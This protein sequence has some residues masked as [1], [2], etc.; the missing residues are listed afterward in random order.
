MDYNEDLWGVSEIND[1]FTNRNY[2]GHPEMLAQCKSFGLGV[3][4]Y[5]REVA[6][7]GLGMRAHTVLELLQPLYVRIRSS[8]SY[9]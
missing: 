5:P 9:I 6:G 4:I 7:G 8:E 2:M 3:W 1:M